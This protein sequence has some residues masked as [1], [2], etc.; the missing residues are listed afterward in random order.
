M[1][2]YKHPQLQLNDGIE[3]LELADHV[4]VLQQWLKN[5]GILPKGS[6]VDGRFGPF[7][8]ASVERFQTLRPPGSQFVAEGLQVTGGVDQN[9]WAELLKVSPS[10]IEMLPRPEATTILTVS[11]FDTDRI[12]QNAVLSDLRSIA[13][14]TVPLILAECIANSV[15]DKGKIAYILATAEHESHLGNLMTEIGDEDYFSHSYDPPSGV[16]HDL[17]NINKGDGPKYRGRG[18]VQITGR[19]NYADWKDRLGVDLVNQPEM[20]TLPQI[21][22]KVLVIGSIKGTFTGA[23]LGDFIAG[24]TR[25]FFNARQ[26]IN[27]HDRAKDIAEIAQIY[28]NTLT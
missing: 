28:Y 8:K 13:R 6:K 24:N 2:I 10:E 3:I 11:G 21:A 26:V 7:T 22:A 17:G 20:A 5:W 15:T 25:D 4:E 16:A 12:I 19:R 1:A 23:A 27:G 9:T 18:F 14:R